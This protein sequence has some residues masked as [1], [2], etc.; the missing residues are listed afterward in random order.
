MADG[1]RGVFVQQQQRHGFADDVAAPHHHRA[2]AGDGD[3]VALQNSMMPAGVH[4]RGP[5]KSATS[6]A[7]VEGVKAVHVLLRRQGQQHALGIHLFGHGQL[8]QDAIDLGARVQ[9]AR[10]WPASLRW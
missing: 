9:T 8:H 4:A 5:G 2:L 7:D 1:D 6:S 10:R 3:P